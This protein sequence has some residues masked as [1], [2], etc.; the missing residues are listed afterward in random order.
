MIQGKQMI[1][2]LSRLNA[3]I[4]L[5]LSIYEPPALHLF[6]ASKENL[7]P[8]FALAHACIPCDLQYFLLYAIL[9]HLIVH[10]NL[11]ILSKSEKVASQIADSHEGPL[12]VFFDRFPHKT[13]LLDIRL[14]LF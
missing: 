3:F 5:N 14:D 2:L 7:L 4:N 8:A 9:C 13:P 10:A 11:S 12:E 6:M 1:N